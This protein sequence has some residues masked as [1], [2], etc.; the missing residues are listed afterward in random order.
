[1][2]LNKK[3]TTELCFSVCIC[4]GF[5]LN[6]ISTYQSLSI[7]IFHHFSRAR[8]YMHESDEPWLPAE[9]G[10]RRIMLINFQAL[11]LFKLFTCINNI[12]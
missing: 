3:K 4:D 1:M 8:I 2:S 11:Y 10:H 9:I 7:F 12:K 6:Y 5:N